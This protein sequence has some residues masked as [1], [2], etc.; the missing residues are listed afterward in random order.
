MMK[1]TFKDT[2]PILTIN[3]INLEGWD[4]NNLPP[5]YSNQNGIVFQNDQDDEK[6]EEEF[7]NLIKEFTLK[8]FENQNVEF[9]IDPISANKTIEPLDKIPY[10]FNSIVIGVDKQNFKIRYNTIQEVNFIDDKW[11]KKWT[12]DFYFEKLS[13]VLEKETNV[14]LEYEKDDVFISLEIILRTDSK[15]IEEAVNKTI[16]DLEKLLNKVEH[17]LNGLE[18]FFNAIELWN[19]NKNQKSEAYWQKTFKKYSWILSLAINEPTVIFNNEAFVG[20]KGLSNAN[21]NVIDFV[22][23]NRISDTCALIEIKTPQTKLTG[24]KYRNLF[25]ISTECTGALNQLLNYRDSFQKDYYSLV[26]NSKDNFEII[27]PRCYLIIGNHEKLNKI[28]KK[29]FE[30]FR[31][32]LSNV[33]VLTYD[34]LFE[35][36]FFV[37]S[38]LE[39]E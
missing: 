15:N 39:K 12:N 7:Y 32:N 20:G 14:E 27:S 31:K 21:G 11:N 1:L 26:H 29:S 16:N 30:L 23:K 4:T 2:T 28:E 13:K 18:G 5:K 34:E 36:I 38:I 24:K 25:S 3:E 19:K 22:F 10:P 17:S 35:K 37:L 33:T 8:E 6:L 9:V